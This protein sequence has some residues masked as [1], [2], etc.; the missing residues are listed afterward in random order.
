MSINKTEYIKWY[1]LAKNIVNDSSLIPNRTD[2]EIA[3]NFVSTEN[4]LMFAPEGISS[5]NE[6]KQSSI[7]NI[8]FALSEE[9]EIRK[10][11]IGLAFNNVNSVDKIK[12][13]LSGYCR[14]EKN[15]L[16]EE[17]L[18][19]EGEWRITVVRKIKDKHFN[20]VPDYTEEFSRKTNE[21]NDDI[22][23]KIIDISNRIREEGRSN[24]EK[25]KIDTNKSKVAYTET[26]AINLMEC[27]FDLS[28]DIFK[29]RILEAFNVLKI[30]L[31]VKSDSQIRKIEREIGQTIIKTKVM[32]CPKCS[33]SLRAVVI[34]KNR[35]RCGNCNYEFEIS[36][37]Q[38]DK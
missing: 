29:K 8:W 35:A 33:L 22:M 28:E 31:R 19:L 18:N 13:I 9:N 21:I 34:D 16:T 23:N 24:R 32:R 2:K 26:P 36:E 20:Q 6:V 38:I 15:D 10:G 37:D 1:N 5:S 7:P 14:Q 27:E 3:D 30:C 4:W 25:L 11:T 17:L 12:N